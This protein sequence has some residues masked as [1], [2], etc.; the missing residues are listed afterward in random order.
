MLKRVIIKNIFPVYLPFF[1]P[2]VDFALLRNVF[3]AYV[4][5][6]LDKRLFLF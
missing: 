2:F 6:A 3:Y 1:M 4:I 5:E